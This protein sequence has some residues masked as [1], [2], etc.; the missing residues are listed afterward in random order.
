MPAE[1]KSHGEVNVK[2]APARLEDTVLGEVEG[3]RIY[4]RKHPS[5]QAT[6]NGT[7]RERAP[8]ERVAGRLHGM[9]YGVK[10]ERFELDAVPHYDFEAV[11]PGPGAPP[12]LPF[13]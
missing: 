7:H 10:I 8:I 13:G 3:V 11:C 4:A 1:P 9:G 5:G 12:A 2:D 6:V